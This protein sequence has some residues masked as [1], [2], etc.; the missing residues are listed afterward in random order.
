[1]TTQAGLRQLSWRWSKVAG[2]LGRVEPIVV[3]AIHVADG[4]RGELGGAEVVERGQR[5]RDI[6]AADLLD[7]PPRKRTD[8]AGPAEQVMALLRAELVVAEIV[9]A[10]EHAQILRLAADRP[11]ALLGADRA[12]ALARP[13]LEIEVSLE[14]HRAAMAA[15]VVGLLHRERSCFELAASLASC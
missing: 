5:H 13:G 6:V 9:L 4:E 15:A 8:S 11:V 3:A 7:M 10:R 14:P 2:H 1:H 12:V